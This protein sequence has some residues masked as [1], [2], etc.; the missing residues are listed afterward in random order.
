MLAWALS[1]SSLVL[2]GLSQVHRRR[3]Y[4]EPPVCFLPLSCS[5]LQETQP[6]TL[7]GG[8]KLFFFRYSV[9]P[10]R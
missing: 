2:L 8:G 5:L 9:S 6:R 1:E 10:Y 3:T 4:L 7:K